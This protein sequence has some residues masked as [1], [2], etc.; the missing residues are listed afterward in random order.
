MHKIHLEYK[1]FA[2]QCSFQVCTNLLANLRVESAEHSNKHAVNHKPYLQQYESRHDGK[3]LI[4]GLDSTFLIF[5]ILRCYSKLSDTK[6][7]LGNIAFLS[8]ENVKEL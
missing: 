2:T 7:L 3:N 1:K 8:V 6:F 4:E 5:S